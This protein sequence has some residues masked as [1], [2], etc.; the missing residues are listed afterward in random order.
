MKELRKAA[1]WQTQRRYCKHSE[2]QRPHTTMACVTRIFAI[3]M[4]TLLILLML[5]SV[6][7]GT[8]ATVTPGKLR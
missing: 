7:P 8:A 1:R 4:E 2:T 6:E 5:I 3:I